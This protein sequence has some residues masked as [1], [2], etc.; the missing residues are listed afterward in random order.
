MGSVGAVAKAVLA[1][2]GN[3]DTTTSKLCAVESK[4]E[5]LTNNDKR[6][7][8]VEKRVDVISSA[9][10]ETKASVDEVRHVFTKQIL[11]NIRLASS[12]SWKT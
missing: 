8:A 9:L 4:V 7:D 5:K 10:S 11:E 1:V 6:H 12:F 3:L 2:D